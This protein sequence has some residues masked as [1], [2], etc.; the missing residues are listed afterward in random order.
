M[1]IT[2]PPGCRR[3]RRC[4]GTGEFARGVCFCCHVASVEAGRVDAVIAALREYHRQ[5]ATEE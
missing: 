4:G 1:I 2:T 3:C 5:H